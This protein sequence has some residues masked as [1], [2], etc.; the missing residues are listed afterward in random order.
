MN[1]PAND[2][3]RETDR[4]LRALLWATLG[5]IIVILALGAVSYIGL[6]GVQSVSHRVAESSEVQL[7]LTEYTSELARVEAEGTALVLDG[8]AALILDDYDTLSSRVV[9]AQSAVLEIH[10]AANDLEGAI[11]LSVSDP[12]GFIAN[13]EQR[14]STP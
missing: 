1:D 6:R 8:L 13:C 4:A 14:R 2:V 10:L 7:C 3:A 12:S 5:F 11:S 9:E